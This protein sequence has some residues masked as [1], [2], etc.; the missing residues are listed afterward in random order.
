MKSDC[1][2]H[3]KYCWIN[4]TSQQHF[5]I[6][7]PVLNLWTTAVI[8]Q[9]GLI[10]YPPAGVLAAFQKDGPVGGNNE[11]KKLKHEVIIERQHEMFMMQFEMQSSE[12]MMQMTE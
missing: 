1:L 3:N 2:N 8:K 5:A 7:F 6:H 12:R 4:T 9:D 10:D 11:Q